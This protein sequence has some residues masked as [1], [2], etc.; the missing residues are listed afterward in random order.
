M[1]S[2]AGQLDLNDC[3]TS[4]CSQKARPGEEMLYGL[5]QA[6]ETGQVHGQTRDYFIGSHHLPVETIRQTEKDQKSLYGKAFG[7][8]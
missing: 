2:S 6:R 3:G 4:I 7:I 5:A 8:W 1:Q